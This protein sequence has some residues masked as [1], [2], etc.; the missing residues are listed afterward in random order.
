MGFS[1]TYSSQALTDFDDESLLELADNSAARN[2]PLGITGYLYYRDGH[3][4]QYLEGE[5]KAVEE[6]MARIASDPRHTILSEVPLPPQ[7]SAIFPHW[8]M[9]FLGSNLPQK[10][11]ATIED[12]LLSLIHI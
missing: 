12:E 3:F 4:I 10:Q 8:Y 7:P 1:L 2:E 6:L 5:Q 9:R 11:A